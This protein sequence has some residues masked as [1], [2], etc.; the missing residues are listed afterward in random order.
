MPDQISITLLT[1]THPDGDAVGS[2]IGLYHF[3]KALGYQPKVVFPDNVPD[4]LKHLLPD[5]VCIH[6]EEKELGD[7]LLENCDLLIGLDFNQY[8]RTGSAQFAA[9]RS[10]ARKLL[11]DHH[12]APDI[13]AFDQVYSEPQRSS[14][15][16]LLYYLLLQHPQVQGKPACI[17][18]KALYCLTTGL[19]TDTNNFNNSISPATFRMA[20]DVC[21]QGIDLDQ[22]NEQLFRSNR[23]NR[24]DLMG[25]LLENRRTFLPEYGAEYL[26]FTLE[27]QKKFDYLPGES[28]GFV[29]L[30]LQTKR[31]RISAL[32]TET[33]EGH[34][35][36]SLRSKRGFSANRL[37]RMF[38]N[39][40]GH[41]NAAGGRLFIPMDQVPGYFANAV[42][43]F[44][45]QEQDT[46]E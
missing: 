38:F 27:D 29:N 39:G 22:I 5:P 4:N 36:V 11:I 41:E 6:E 23:P 42:G 37:A 7:R 3:L 2:S 46:R 10:K 34:V 24:M 19:I 43:V 45:Q 15:C 31:V 14:T 9:A 44:L 21:E 35:R 1:H 13:P 32:F 20:A 18:Q 30:P 26:L 8:S 25:F 40:G 28:E 33:A 12:L 17:P 16:E